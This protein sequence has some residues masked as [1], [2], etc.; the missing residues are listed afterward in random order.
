M[1]H[2]YFVYLHPK[3]TFEEKVSGL[4]PNRKARMDFKANYGKEHGKE[5]AEED[6]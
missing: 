2:T 1:R 4:N 5:E 3:A 6:E